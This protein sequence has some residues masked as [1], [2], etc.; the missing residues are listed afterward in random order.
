MQDGSSTEHVWVKSVSYDGE[1]FHGVLDNQPARHRRQAGRP[2]DGWS[3]RDLRLDVP[4][5]SQAG[6]RVHDPGRAV[7]VCQQENGENSIGKP[8]SRSKRSTEVLS[9]ADPSWS[10]YGIW[11]PSI[12]GVVP[13][14]A[15]E[16]ACT[17]QSLR[18]RW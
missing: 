15:Q 7:R 12:P 2:S 13:F 10:G 8:R 1:H 5:R 4:S 9:E 17:S 18:S 16:S 6:G 3:K 11:S 14:L